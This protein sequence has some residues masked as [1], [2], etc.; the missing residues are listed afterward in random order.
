MLISIETHI[1]CDFPRGGGGPTPYPTLWIRTCTYFINIWGANCAQQLD[2]KFLA[3]DFQIEESGSQD[4]LIQNVSGS[5]VKMQFCN[6][7]IPHM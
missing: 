3:L 6:L 1:T 4:F 2:F 5:T 7:A